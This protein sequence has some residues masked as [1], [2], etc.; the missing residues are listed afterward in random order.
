LYKKRGIPHTL[1]FLLWGEPG[2]GKTGFI[3]ALMNKTKR[4]GISIKLNNKFDLNKLRQ[5]LYNEEITDELCIPLD[6]RIIIFEDIDCMSDIVKT[7]FTDSEDDNNSEPDDNDNKKEKENEKENENPLLK[8]LSPLKPTPVEFINNNLSYL[9]NILDGLEEYPGRIIIMT[10]NQ[11][12][13]LDKALIRPGR[14]D[15][16]IEFTNATLDDIKKII[17]YYWNCEKTLTTHQLK[18][19]DNLLAKNN[20]LDKKYSHAY[21]VNICRSTDNFEDCL[22]KLI[23]G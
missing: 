6:K 13:K 12:D 20:F 10:S 17:I 1:G 16:I 7:R 22:L 19:L 15:H 5:I 11:P 9:L 21:V 3:K 23:S 8:L 4:H 14:I 2:C 18:Y